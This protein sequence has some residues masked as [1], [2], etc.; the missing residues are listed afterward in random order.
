MS[1][2][3]QPERTKPAIK[4]VA[5]LPDLI[6]GDEYVS[7]PAGERVRLRVRATPEGVEIL[8]DAARADRLEA[9]LRELDVGEIEQMLC[10]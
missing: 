6:R 9:L 1:K 8:G 10:G 7:D 5:D 2:P 3:E 4:F